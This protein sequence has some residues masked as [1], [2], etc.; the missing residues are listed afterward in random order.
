MIKIAIVGDVG[1]GKSYIS[2]LF[3]YP[4]FNADL[5]VSKIYKKDKSFYKKLK[6]RFPKFNFTFPIK[7]N[8]L[9]NCIL[10]NQS[11]LKKVSSIVHPIVREKLQIFLKKNKRKKIVILDIPLYLE[12]KLDKKKD[13]IIYVQAK[14]KDIYK[15][16]KKRSGFNL[17]LYRLFKDF[18]LPLYIKKKKS[19]FIIKNNFSNKSEKKI[20]KYILNKIQT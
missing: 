13:V 7:K 6:K 10:K 4:I 15:R 18:Q 17:K 9:I 16:L 1:S 11:N 12:N 19:N 14:K 3:N 2:K 20:I 5:E 8:E